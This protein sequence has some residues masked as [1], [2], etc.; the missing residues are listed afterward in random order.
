MRPAGGVHPVRLSTHQPGEPAPGLRCPGKGLPE[1]GLTKKFQLLKDIKDKSFN[2]FNASNN[3]YYCVIF[4]LM[5]F[6]SILGVA[7]FSWDSH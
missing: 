5:L 7:Y 3:Y 6:L 4:I 2:F 1:K